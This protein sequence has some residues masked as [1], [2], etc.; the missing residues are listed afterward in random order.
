MAWDQSLPDNPLHNRSGQRVQGCR[1]TAVTERL[2]RRYVVRVHGGPPHRTVLEPGA[3][4]PESVRANVMLH[5]W[6]A[7]L[8]LCE[9]RQSRTVRVSGSKSSQTCSLVLNGTG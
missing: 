6:T 3:A 2:T 8:R 7:F 5:V 9:I 4:E 1:C